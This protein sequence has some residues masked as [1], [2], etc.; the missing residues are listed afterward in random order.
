[1]SVYLGWTTAAEGLEFDAKHAEREAF[2]TADA[3]F[4]I[5]WNRRLSTANSCSTSL[6]ERELALVVNAALCFTASLVERHAGSRRRVAF[7][8][9]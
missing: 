8:P 7:R 5:N 9:N 2:A 6:R 4:P 3:F 1:M